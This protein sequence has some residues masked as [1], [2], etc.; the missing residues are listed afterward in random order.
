MPTFKKQA[1]LNARG[2][3]A[4]KGIANNFGLRISDFDNNDIL[5][6]TLARRDQSQDGFLHALN[7]AGIQYKTLKHRGPSWAYMVQ[8]WPKGERPS[9]EKMDS[10]KSTGN[11]LDGS[12]YIRRAMKIANKLLLLA[13]SSKTIPASELSFELADS[14]AQDKGFLHALKTLKTLLEKKNDVDKDELLGWIIG[15]MSQLEKQINLLEQQLRKTTKTF[16]SPSPVEE[17]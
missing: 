2:R 14:L 13:V 12:T 16:T 11:D 5:S 6:F 15:R 8:L 7:K 9:G 1:K 17:K 10:T 3:Q 4:V